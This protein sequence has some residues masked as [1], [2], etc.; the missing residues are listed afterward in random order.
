[1]QAQETRDLAPLA[2]YGL[3]KYGYLKQEVGP[4][5]ERKEKK[6]KRGRKR[7]KRGRKEKGSLLGRSS[8]L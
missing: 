3:Q 7:K 1:V 4:A 2:A 6:K 8:R 5:L